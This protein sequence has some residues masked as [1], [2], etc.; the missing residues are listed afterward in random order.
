TILMATR[1]FTRFISLARLSGMRSIVVSSLAVATFALA[2]VANAQIS[3]NGDGSWS[4]VS[5]ATNSGTPFWDNLS[6]DGTSCNIGSIL[7]GTAAGCSNGYGDG[8]ALFGAGSTGLEHWAGSMGTTSPFTFSSNQTL[9]I[10]IHGGWA[11]GSSSAGVFDGSGF[12]T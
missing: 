1:H 7:L 6:F 12:S 10:T 2:S 8:S 11:R 3:V 4:S 5:G 9:K